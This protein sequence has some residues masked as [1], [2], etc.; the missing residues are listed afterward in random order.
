MSR[1]DNTSY[2]LYWMYKNLGFKL[3]LIA[4]LIVSEAV[5]R[6]QTDAAWFLLA[7]AV[8]LFTCKFKLIQKFETPDV[9]VM[10]I[11]QWL[12]EVAL[13]LVL[14]AANNTA[15]PVLFAVLSVLSVMFTVPYLILVAVSL[16]DYNER[17]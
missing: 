7:F 9:L 12:F 1:K 13:V 6:L 2:I 14:A 4:I 15:S 16:I 17:K 11:R 10:Q 5:K 8:M 3:T